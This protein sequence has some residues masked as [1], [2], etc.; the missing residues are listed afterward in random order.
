[1]IIRSIHIDRFGKWNGLRLQNLESGINL[2]YGPN[3]T[4]KT[5]L[6]Q[7]IRTILYGFSKN[8]LAYAFKD[9][10][11]KTGGDVLVQTPQGEWCIKRH[12]VPCPEAMR[13][14]AEKSENLPSGND[15]KEES[16]DLPFYARKSFRKLYETRSLEDG[17]AITDAAGVKQDS[18]QWKNFLELSGEPAGSFASLELDEKL[19]N[20]I[21]AMGLEELQKLSVLD[22]TEAAKR[23]YDLSTGIARYSVV[24]ILARLTRVRQK[25]LPLDAIPERLKPED[26]NWNEERSFVPWFGNRSGALGNA[27][28]DGNSPQKILSLLNYRQLLESQQENVQTQN[29]KYGKF[30]SERIAAEQSIQKLQD[31][32]Q[33]QNHK[34]RILEIAQKVQPAWEH[35]EALD[36]EI[37]S[38]GTERPELMELP[39]SWIETFAENQKALQRLRQ[40]TDEI[41]KERNALQE[42]AEETRK[43]QDALL[44]NSELF[45][46]ISAIE[47]FFQ[48]KDWIETLQGRLED[49]SRQQ[50]DSEAQLT[51]DYRRLG[52]ALPVFSSLE[53]PETIFPYDVRTLRPLRMP[54]REIKKIQKKIQKIKKQRFEQLRQAEECA[55]KIGAYFRACRER[56]ER[57][58]GLRSLQGM[59]AFPEIFLVRESD[60]NEVL[61]KNAS[62]S[63]NRALNALN[64]KVVSEIPAEIL[65]RGAASVKLNAVRDADS[66]RNSAA[67]RSPLA[68]FSEDW[69]VEKDSAPVLMDVN[70]AARLLGE[71][72]AGLRRSEIYLQQLMQALKTLI[73]LQKDR[74]TANRQRFLTTPELCAFGGVFSLGLTLSLFEMLRLTH[75]LPSNSSGFLHFFLFLIG[76]LACLGTFLGRFIFLQKIHQ[77]IIAI[78]DSLAGARQQRERLIRL[79]F[80]AREEGVVSLSDA[81]LSARC[82]EEERDFQTK[83][84]FLEKE[85][86]EAENAGV[87]ASQRAA[88]LL[89][90]KHL[91]GRLRKLR[92]SAGQANA[93]RL[94]VLR[95][96]GLPESWKAA[97]VR[98]LIDASDRIRELW[99]RRSRD[100][101]DFQLYSQE[102]TH[103][104]ERLESFLPVFGDEFAQSLRGGTERFPFIP[105]VFTA[106]KNRMEEEKERQ[107]KAE[108]LT[109]K[110]ALLRARL[111]KIRASFEKNSR[112]RQQILE[113]AQV[114]GEKAL[115]EKIEK[116]KVLKD[117]RARRR[118]CQKEIDAAVEFSCTESMLWEVY[119][120]NSQEQI[121]EKLKILMNSVS[122]N[123][124]QLKSAQKRSEECQEVLK[125]IISDDS[126][127]RI[128]YELSRV[129]ALLGQAVRNWRVSAMTQ[130]LI[131]T[132]QK[133]YQQKRQPKTLECAS[134]Y[135][136]EMTG[137]RYERVWT[138]LDEDLL[139]VQCPDGASFSAEQLSTGTRELLYLAIRLALIEEYRQRN[140]HL[141]IILDD[142]FVNFDQKRAEAAARLLTR[143]AGEQTQI[144]FFTSHEHIRKIFAKENALICDME[145]R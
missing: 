31:E 52:L 103:L 144:F 18:F 11:E 61:S 119:E 129:N 4:G 95:K 63:K 39:D 10:P 58:P 121:T 53:P 137:G 106:L 91:S 51:I 74:A 12:L 41:R 17:L 23:L 5:T 108:A 112:M 85:L 135:F 93:R 136:A 75:F 35:R 131:E 47:S 99:R 45:Q 8:R 22:S 50:A 104:V 96:L 115:H 97:N 139:F 24:E 132:I 73:Q 71:T 13:E 100:L 114:T 37:V 117:L 142:V 7:F 48:Q 72:L 133:T 92:Q 3:E 127:V 130:R 90:V 69:N 70:A 116:L 66:S 21:F 101:E 14:P 105:G 118:A 78:E 28:S 43:M 38:F 32:I 68:E 94:E 6:M 16:A 107:K 36:A 26:L 141:P 98:Q 15:S 49:L 2:F 29:K 124:F 64:S 81:E 57:N 111:K 140:V 126:P 25:L 110:K 55:L 138:P 62:E 120:N 113:A 123:D 122:E 134:D 65:N 128:Q 20:S 145:K 109:Q 87:A 86:A 46:K 54:G 33:Q 40:E 83:I 77:K 76:S 59:S 44:L 67:S 143:F 9:E 125:K 82:E 88:L 80:A 30:H 1:M 27:I 60:E 89:E 42:Q 79:F 102:L 84:A 34:I 19:F 56:M